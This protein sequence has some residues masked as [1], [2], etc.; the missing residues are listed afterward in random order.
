MLLIGVALIAAV[1][2]CSPAKADGF[3]LDSGIT[4]L[5]NSK[6]GNYSTR[7]EAVEVYPVQG[8]RTF[9]TVP[10]N[11]YTASQYDIN[12]VKNPYAFIAA[13]YDLSL[14]NFTFDFKAH[15]RESVATGLDK[16]EFGVTASVRWYPFGGG[17]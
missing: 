11:Y 1:I 12:Q 10:V 2:M 3:Y 13:G 4:V 16:G 17:K 15:R 9:K 8:I 5:N 6:P 14:G 7:L